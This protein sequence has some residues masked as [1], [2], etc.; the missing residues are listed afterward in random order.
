MTTVERA[1]ISGVPGRLPRL[2]R[3]ARLGQESK[4]NLSQTARETRM[5]HRRSSLPFAALHHRQ[6]QRAF[7]VEIEGTNVQSEWRLH[8]FV[9]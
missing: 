6:L 5:G 4:R 7:T 1:W 8:P 3:L 9:D 2:A